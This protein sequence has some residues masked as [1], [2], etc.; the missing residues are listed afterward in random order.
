MKRIVVLALAAAGAVVVGQRWQARQA[1]KALWAEITDPAPQEASSTGE[2][3]HT[4]R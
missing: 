3:V 4:D 2:V 1:E